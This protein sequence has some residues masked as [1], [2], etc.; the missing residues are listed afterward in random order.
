MKQ[1]YWWAQ[2]RV[3]RNDLLCNLLTVQVLQLLAETTEEKSKKA[4][5]TY[6]KLTVEL[7]NKTTALK[8]KLLT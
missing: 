3:R 1:T 5:F 6:Q 7:S 4:F 2:E 8:W